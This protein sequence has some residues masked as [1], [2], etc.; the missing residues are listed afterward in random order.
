[1]VT[2]YFV[3]CP[4]C[5]GCW[6]SLYLTFG[7]QVSDAIDVTAANA[8]LLVQAQ[9]TKLTNL[10]A[11]YANVG[12]D[13]AATSS[14]STSAALC[15]SAGSNTIT[16]N[17]YS[18]IGNI[19]GLGIIDSSLAEDPAYVNLGFD[20]GSTAN[21]TLSSNLGTGDLF[22]CSNQGIC[23]RRTGQCRCNLGV[24]GTGAGVG[25]GYPGTDGVS[26]LGRT[27]TEPGSAYSPSAEMINNAGQSN[28]PR[29]GTFPKIAFRA[30][31]SDVNGN[32][33]SR[34]DCGYLVRANAG[35]S[36]E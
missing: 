10:T 6:G 9:V 1:M 25:L 18:A 22:E 3:T 26:V 28:A 33:G 11:A 14:L 34:G 4:A 5:S 13:Y 29:P 35:C 16:I 19:A 30:S 36:G 23:D 2:Q 24:V 7:E 32:S 20:E 31:S 27:A 17:L 12:F 21:V 15:S 8:P